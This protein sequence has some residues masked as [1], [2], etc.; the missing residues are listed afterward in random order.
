[1]ND[2]AT[3]IDE[4]Y[5][6]SY[7]H[8]SIHEEMI[9]DYVRTNTYRKAILENAADFKDKVVVDVGCGTCILSFFCIQAGAKKVYA[10]DA[11]DIVDYAKLVVES[12]HMTDKIIIMK[13]KVEDLELPEKVDII[14]SEWMGYFLLYEAM[15]D[16]VIVARDKWL[17]PDGLMF[18]SKA[19]IFLCALADEQ[20]YKEK[21]DF[22][23]NV[24][25]I[26]MSALIPFAKKCAFE[27]PVVDYVPSQNLLAFPKRI[28]T[29]DCKTVKISDLQDLKCDFEFSSIIVSDF[30]GFISWF[31]VLFEG[32]GKIAPIRLSTS[33]DSQYT[34]WKQ[35]TL[36]IE[37]PVQIVQDQKIYGTLRVTP[38]QENKRYIDTSI[39]Y[40]FSDDSQPAQ[41]R[42]WIMR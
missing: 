7:A 36:Y 31:D 25:N 34:H 29:L 10:V 20:V 2:S 38:N 37:E 9:K 35:V 24:Y 41:T 40:Q 6:E 27:E 26:D 1:M 23:Q 15:L 18:P 5:F 16:T 4:D 21:L 19:E 42:V 32:S 33:P 39:T 13:G 12:N 22:W 3:R 30:C 11:S 14:I 17:K 8:L 28:F